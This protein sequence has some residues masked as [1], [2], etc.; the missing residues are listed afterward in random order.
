MA[1]SR[2]IQLLNSLQLQMTSPKKSSTTS[3]LAQA[4]PIIHLK[5]WARPILLQVVTLEIRLKPL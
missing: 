4:Q 3:V 5:L 2:P 1:N